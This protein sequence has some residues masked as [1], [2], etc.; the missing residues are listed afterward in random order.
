MI[1]THVNINPVGMFAAGRVLVPIQEKKKNV[2]RGT[3]LG[4]LPPLWKSSTSLG[5]V[6]W[7]MRVVTSGVAWYP[8]ITKNEMRVVTSGA[9]WCPV[10]H[11]K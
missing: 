4:Y 5:R 10:S 11:K 1:L 3:S 2:G 7:E 6:A 8:V 9:G